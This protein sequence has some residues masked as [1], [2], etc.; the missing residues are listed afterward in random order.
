MRTGLCSNLGE[1]ILVAC[2]AALDTAYRR[3]KALLWHRVK[4]VRARRING[5]G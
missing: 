3:A 5:A 2:V 1:E 4:D